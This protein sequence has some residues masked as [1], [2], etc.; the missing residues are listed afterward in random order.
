MRLGNGDRRFEDS[1]HFRLTV[2]P[3]AEA[4]GQL[5]VPGPGASRLDRSAPAPDPERSK[6]EAAGGRARMCAAIAQPIG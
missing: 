3:G 2:Y 1:A 5:Y 4:G 6:R